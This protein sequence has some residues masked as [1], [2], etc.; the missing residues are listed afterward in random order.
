MSHTGIVAPGCQHHHRRTYSGL[1]N[2]SNTR[3]RGASKVRRR[4]ISVSEGNVTSRVPL[5]RVSGM[6]LLLGFQLVEDGVEAVE[7]PLPQGPVLVDPVGRVAQPPG[8]DPAR[9]ALGV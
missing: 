8:D 3:C 2:A 6:T 9:P 1:V 7:P 5:A 4:R